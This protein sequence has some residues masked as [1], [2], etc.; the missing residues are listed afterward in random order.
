MYGQI[1]AGHWQAILQSL[2]Q[3]E[4]LVTKVNH[5]CWSKMLVTIDSQSKIDSTLTKLELK[6]FEML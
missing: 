4:M 6:N 5:K 2:L 1:L 3:Q